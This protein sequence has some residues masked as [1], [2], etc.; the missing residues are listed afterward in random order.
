VALI[1]C[2]ECRKEAS[3]QAKACPHCGYPFARHYEPLTLP[4]SWNPGIAAVLSLVIP[5]AG[6][7]YKGEVG[8]GIV[9]LLCVAVGYSMFVFPGLILHI[10]CIVNA[11]KKE[12]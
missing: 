2:P 5:G 1:S 7:M 6:Q 8:Q 3:D 9:W 11:S 12:E 10:I 4:G